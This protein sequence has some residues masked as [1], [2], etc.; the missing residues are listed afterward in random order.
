MILGAV[1]MGPLGVLMALLARPQLA[2]WSLLLLPVALEIV[3]L[4][5]YS[6]HVTTVEIAGGWIGAGVGYLLG[7]HLHRLRRLVERPALWGVAWYVL[8]LAILGALLL[9]HDQVLRDSAEI[10]NRFSSAWELPL[11]K[12]YAGSEYNA[13]T[14]LLAKIGVFSLL[15]S[16]GFGWQ[17]AS[18]Q[19]AGRMLFWITAVTVIVTAF[20]IE[21][22]Q[23]FL[24][25]LVPDISD[26]FTYLL[27]YVAGY[28]VMRILWGKTPP[29]VVRP[30]DTRLRARC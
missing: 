20:L 15:G 23:V 30:L 6:K 22:L 28:Q 26:A 14:N 5:L 19:P 29:R 4:P 18:S 25:P 16:I 27:G 11:I 10:G 12:Y 3:Q 7:L 13:Y 24:P 9:R 1:R 2:R 21:L 8:F 17:Q